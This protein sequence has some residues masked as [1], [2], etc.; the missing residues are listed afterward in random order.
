MDIHIHMRAA[1][2]KFSAACQASGQ[3]PNPV[4]R[5]KVRGAQPRPIPQRGLPALPRSAI[6]WA[7]SNVH[8][9]PNNWFKSF[10]A[11]TPGRP[12]ATLAAAP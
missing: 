2:S 12:Q 4:S 10:A 11:L 7:F 5:L 3:S 6:V 1:I 9:R 8:G